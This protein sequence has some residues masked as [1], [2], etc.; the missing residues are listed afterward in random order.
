MGST[1]CVVKKK[2]RRTRSP[3]VFCLCTFRTAFVLC[4][5]CVYTMLNTRKDTAH[6]I[7]VYIVRIP[8]SIRTVYCLCV[9]IVKYTQRYCALNLCV[10]CTV[11]CLCV[12]FVKYTQRYCALYFCVHVTHTHTLRQLSVHCPI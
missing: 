8:Y 10:H 6:L 12:H 3:C 11:Y 7:C 9:H 5:V 2:A 4:T 1:L